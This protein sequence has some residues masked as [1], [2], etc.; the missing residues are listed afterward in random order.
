M[1]VTKEIVSV[2]EMARMLGLSRARL[3]QL[4][5]EGVFPAPTRP[6]NGARPFFDREQQEQCLTVRRS[7]C[8]I[9]G[10]PIL[11]YTMRSQSSSPPTVPPRRTR[12]QSAPERPRQ[13]TNDPAINEL[14]HGLVQLGIG[15]VGEQSIRTALAEAYPDG[16][17]QVDRA[18]LLRSV[19]AYLN[20]QDSNDNVAR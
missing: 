11:F 9:D 19:F 2:S 6:D 16:W 4:M 7:N 12:R 3:Y 8:G 17:S 18:E 5:K 15:Q 20:R 13:S 14:R 10:R 1:Q